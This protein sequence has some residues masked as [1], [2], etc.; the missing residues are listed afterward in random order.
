MLS[1]SS[2]SEGIKRIQARL[3]KLGA[4]HRAGYRQGSVISSRSATSTDIF[5]TDWDEIKR[6]VEDV[7]IPASAIDA[8]RAFIQQW[9]KEAMEA[10]EFDEDPSLVHRHHEPTAP[11]VMLSESPETLFQKPEPSTLMSPSTSGFRS[12]A[13]TM[14]DDTGYQRPSDIDDDIVGPMTRMTMP[15]DEPPVRVSME[16]GPSVSRRGTDLFGQKWQEIADATGGDPEAPV[17]LQP[18]T[19]RRKS[20]GL[21]QVMFKLFSSNQ[22]IIQAA[23]DGNAQEVERLLSLGVDGKSPPNLVRFSENRVC[24]L[25]CT[26]P[27]QVLPESR[28]GS[29]FCPHFLAPVS[30]LHVY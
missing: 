21:N 27:S 8:N 9:L 22:R 10:G 3:R 4:E 26:V 20:S 1:D 23:S 2:Y 25:G 12:S 29:G 28:I 7:G 19:G 24:W 18:L 16:G 17:A 6:E 15:E 30:P 11:S 14:V 13:P 5:I